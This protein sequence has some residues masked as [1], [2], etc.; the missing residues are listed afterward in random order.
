MHSLRREWRD[1]LMRLVQ[2]DAPVGADLESLR[3]AGSGP[4]LQGYLAHK[5]QPP[6]GAP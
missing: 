2:E 4:L 6:L 3:A 5:K 1:A